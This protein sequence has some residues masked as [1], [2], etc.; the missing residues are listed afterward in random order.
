M[1]DLRLAADVAARL[2]ALVTREVDEFADTL[3]RLNIPPRLQVPLWN[4]MARRAT[5]KAIE[6]DAEA[7][8]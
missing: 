3:A 6:A 1:T 4:A 7:K 8:R 2:E 5:V